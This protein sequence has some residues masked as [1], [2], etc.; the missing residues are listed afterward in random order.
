MA[1]HLVL[2]TLI[3]VPL[4]AACQPDEA[5]TD[6]AD[7]S[8]TEPSSTTSGSPEPTTASSASSEA[9]PG[10]TT[11]E[12]TTV[13]PTSG[14]SG[15]TAEPTST[16][17]SV[18][19]SSTNADAE[20]GDG[21]VG[22]AEECDDENRV[23][24]DG[25]SAGCQIEV[26][27]VRIC[28]G[29]SRTCVVDEMAR[30]KCWGAGVLG[31]V[32]DEP[33]EMGAD[34]PFVDL[35]MDVQEITCQGHFCA[36]GSEGQVKCWGGAKG[37]YLGLGTT[38]F[39]GDDPDE[40]GDAL[41]AVEL[42][43]AAVAIGNSARGTCALLESGALKCWGYNAEG[44]LG[45]GD[46]ATRGDSPGEMGAAL[47][48]IDLGDMSPT[49]VVAGHHANC[50]L[51]DLGR[52][53]CWGMGV[54][55]GLENWDLQGDEPADMGDAL[56]FVDVGAGAEIAQ[57]SATD[58]T[59]C[60]VLVDG[61]LKCW[62]ED[63]G[64]HVL[65]PFASSTYYGWMP[66]EMG[67]DLPA[68]DLGPSKAIAVATGR[69]SACVQ[70]ENKSLKCWG[71]NTFGLMGTGSDVAWPGSPLAQVPAIDLGDGETVERF[72]HGFH[73]ACAIVSGGRVKC[74]GDNGGGELGYGDTNHRGDEP[75]EMGDALPYVE[76]F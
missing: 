59:T 34:L 48:A 10:T 46:T 72:S 60:V 49:A 4:A 51:D 28:A 23:S 66:G 40:M 2:I 36:L 32:G 42:G 9:S 56:P 70:L 5:A 50:A 52:L 26:P 65:W 39:V 55:L 12:A 69:H 13:E 7:V 8:T 71:G 67:D 19:D 58:G 43:E 74:W 25:C 14:E 45:L 68:Y 30:L 44:Q 64:S 53:K 27:I 54:L 17:T 18:D 76:I 6:S 63:D 41:P 38:E 75:D 29:A 16:A 31:N 11:A 22:G 62:G 21:L 24:F 57:A 35:G 47:P 37:D 73:H 3:A 33:G 20:C 15:S 1:R 61:R